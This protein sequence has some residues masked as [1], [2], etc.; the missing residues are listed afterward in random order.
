MKHSTKSLLGYLKSWH[1]TSTQKQRDAGHYVD[2]TF[3]EFLNLFDTDQLRYLR[4]AL[5]DGKIRERQN[6]ENPKALVLTW[7]SYAA[8]SSCEFT[9]DTAFVCDR[10]TSFEVN[11]SQAGDTLR[12][13]HV[14]NIRDSLTGVPKSAAHRA[15][16]SE[17]CKGVKKAA[18]TPERKAMMSARR[19]AEQAAKR[20]A[21]Q[22]GE[23]DV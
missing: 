15:A 18:W 10:Q 14:E 19:K 3:C 5:M 1:A 21:Q 16:I 8:R 23:A 9:R 11:R 4:R 2:L 13:E 12:V 17:G 6:E 22:G 20:I 7:R